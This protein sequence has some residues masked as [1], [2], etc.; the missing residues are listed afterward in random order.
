M[1]R[2]CALSTGPGAPGCEA[3]L[4]PD[5]MRIFAACADAAGGRG[6]AVAN[7]LPRLR[8]L[9]E[10]NDQAYADALVQ[11]STLVL[12]AR[13]RA[14]EGS[15]A[16][17]E[18]LS[19]AAGAS[20]AAGTLLGQILELLGPRTAPKDRQ[21]RHR[22][23]ELLW[24]LLAAVR[25][26]DP[27]AES[28]LLRMSRDKIPAI[29]HAAAPGLALME[30][31]AA[32]DALVRLSRDVAPKLRLASL[33][34]LQMMLAAKEA[35]LLGGFAS[36]ARLALDHC[37]AVRR[38]L[39]TTLGTL[40]PLAV[41]AQLPRL[42]L[43]GLRDTC[44]EVSEE[45]NGML[46]TWLEQ[47]IST[48]VDGQEGSLSSVS[49]RK[50]QLFAL[51]ELILAQPGPAEAAVEEL[52]RHL[53]PH[54]EWSAAA[55]GAKFDSDS[56]AEVL[57]C[58]VMF[59]MD[60]ETWGSV[61]GATLLSSALRAL[62][63]GRFADLQ[64]L[65]LLIL[66]AELE[67]HLILQLV[68]AVLLRSPAQ[69]QSS[70]TS[71]PSSCPVWEAFPKAKGDAV[72]AQ[73]GIFHLAVAV[74]R[75]A[76]GIRAGA[77]ESFVRKAEGRFADAMLVILDVLRG[78]QGVEDHVTALGS[79][80][81]SAQGKA[82]A[83][84]SKV[85]DIRK[86]LQ[87][88]AAARDFVGASRIRGQLS[89]LEQE[90]VSLETAAAEAYAK[91][92]AHLWHILGVVEAMLSYSSADLTQHF[93]MALLANDVLRPS[94]V[95][96]DMAPPGAGGISWPSLRALAVRCVAL[97]ASMSVDG[98]E[99]HWPFFISVFKRYV[100]IL[101]SS[102]CHANEA[103]V[104][105]CLAFLSDALNSPFS[106]HWPDTV[107]E[108]RGQELLEALVPLTACSS[109]P[110]R[111]RRC[112]ATRLCSLLLFL[113]LSSSPAHGWV[114]SWLLLQA[115]LREP[116]APVDDEAMAAAATAGR[117]LRFFTSLGRLS[118]EHAGVL[119]AASLSFL[120]LELWQMGTCVQ[121]SGQRWCALPLPRLVSLLSRQLA[122][123][124]QAEGGVGWAH[125]QQ[126]SS[127]VLQLWLDG[128]WRPLALICLD[129]AVVSI[130][131]DSELP[132]A[133]LA[134][135]T[136]TALPGTVA[137]DLTFVP[138]QRRPAVVAEIAWVLNRAVELWASW[139]SA[140]CG[141]LPPGLLELRDRLATAANSSKLEEAP[142]WPRLYAGAD[143]RRQQLRLSVAKLGVDV[144]GIL[145]AVAAVAAR[146]VAD[147]V[148]PRPGRARL[149]RLPD[150]DQPDR[151]PRPARPGRESGAKSGRGRAQAPAAKQA[152]VPDRQALLSQAQELTN[153]Q[154]RAWD[155]LR[156]EAG[157]R[158]QLL[159][160]AVT[161]ARS[162]VL[163]R[164]GELTKRV[165]AAAAEVTAMRGWEPIRAEDDVARE[166]QEELD[167]IIHRV[168]L[169]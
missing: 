2:P 72:A 19:A 5:V 132:Q 16:A 85:S 11:C 95:L 83:T 66:R 24:R 123:A 169:L 10:R 44:R 35:A 7:A 67:P 107:R 131:Y 78:A 142:D 60:A 37:P 79:A 111:L 22:C 153:R 71:V 168:H 80:A 121:V 26:V 100:P 73:M 3:D 150:P 63:A 49:A 125:G 25:Q 112:L 163:A 159:H 47:P 137:G 59:S 13:G 101:L 40:G 129:N 9:S 96:A 14:P 92:G 45:C 86:A 162:Q 117:L 103:V 124:G 127:E 109:T 58:G 88:Q 21:V 33:A 116:P 151:L 126:A 141:E 74:A 98:L 108:A 144:A 149:P 41:G 54:A 143:Q 130:A 48:S 166:A 152:E 20:R 46:L 8:M 91:L 135:M 146:A 38:R 128:L 69:W 93:Q 39:Y 31:P 56:S 114:L 50:H 55:Q 148:D 6:A 51:M 65:L 140:T 115:F 34:Q 87:R 134:A 164:L 52:L 68:S 97:H 89:E 82:E 15:E 53:L 30:S 102:S 147:G 27:A 155:E 18:L 119:A 156:A 106:T 32:V 105:H 1:A 118:L 43:W 61:P 145:S 154:H 36:L 28:A 99:Q 62:D 157:A 104:E 139:R 57:L 70:S 12:A 4:L 113:G 76:F 133:L 165:Q 75:H 161:K 17:V 90:L 167:A 77:R 136:A 42:L 158:T 138:M 81:A 23:A 160:A 29:R 94:L 120:S 84:A 110:A 64:Q 122:T